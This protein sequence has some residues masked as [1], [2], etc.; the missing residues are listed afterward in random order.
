MSPVII[1]FAFRSKVPG[2]LVATIS[3]LLVYAFILLAVHPID[4]RLNAELMQLSPNGDGWFSG[5]GL[6]VELTPRQEAA[7]LAVVSDTGRVLAPFTA[8]IFACLYVFLLYC[9]LLLARLVTAICT[10][11]RMRFGQRKL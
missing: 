11:I 4:V 2:W 9:I 5:N 7:M 3:I 8:G 10:R 6:S 1:F